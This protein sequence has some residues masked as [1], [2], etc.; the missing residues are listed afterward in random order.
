MGGRVGR[1]K[2]R[3]AGWETDSIFTGTPGPLHTEAFTHRRLYTK[4]LLYTEVPCTQGSLYTAAITQ[5]LHRAAFTQSSF[6]HR[7]FYTG[8]PLHRAAFTHK[9]LY[10]QTLFHTEAFTQ[11]S[12]Y[13][14]Q[15]LHTEVFTQRSLYTQKLLDRPAFTQKPF[16]H[17]HFYAE[18]LYT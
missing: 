6:T 2:D 9:R 14:E 10:T 18:Q 1:K 11:G 12:L 3:Q 4:Q 17:R 5:P 13:T 16:T 7:R 15:L 8:K